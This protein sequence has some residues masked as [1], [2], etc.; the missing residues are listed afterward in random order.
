MANISVEL[1]RGVTFIAWFT[2]NIRQKN[3]IFGNSFRKKSAETKQ[4]IEIHSSEQIS[5]SN[6][7]IMNVKLKKM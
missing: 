5:Q 1:V 3:S 2:K 6:K 7:M 4:Y